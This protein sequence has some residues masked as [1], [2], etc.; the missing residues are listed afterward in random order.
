MNLRHKTKQYSRQGNSANSL[1]QA[2][3][4][5]R[6]GW[7][8]KAEWKQINAQRN[9]SVQDALYIE[10][11]DP[12][13]V[14]RLTASEAG[15]GKAGSGGYDTDDDLAALAALDEAEKRQCEAIVRRDA[16][17]LDS[18][19]LQTLLH[20]HF[21]FPSF[22]PFQLECITHIPLVVRIVVVAHS[23]HCGRQVAVLSASCFGSAVHI[24]RV[25]TPVADV[26][27]VPPPSTRAE[28]RFLVLCV[29]V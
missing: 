6:R 11:V 1:R 18:A 10:L 13:V 24:G 3:Y 4:R 29:Y 15:G 20:H 8:T 27:S 7:K 12:A 22:R 23:T 26:G 21:G 9:A 19:E 5:E 14:H 16:S 17:S 2:K 28:G 25:A